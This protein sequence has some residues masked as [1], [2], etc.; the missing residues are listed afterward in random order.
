M[1]FDIRCYYDTALHEFP[2]D[3]LPLVYF[4]IS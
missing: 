3:E 2:V 4:N 1:I